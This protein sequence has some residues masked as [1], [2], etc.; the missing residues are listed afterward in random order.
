MGSTLINVDASVNIETTAT[1]KSQNMGYAGN[2][3]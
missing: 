2:G 1:L 3:K